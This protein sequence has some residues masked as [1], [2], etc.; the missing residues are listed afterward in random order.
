M[1]P[2]QIKMLFNVVMTFVLSVILSVVLLDVCVTAAGTLDTGELFDLMGRPLPEEHVIVQTPDPDWGKEDPDEARFEVTKTALTSSARPGDTVTYEIRIENTGN[3]DLHSV[4]STE[5]FLG[6]GIK[7]VF[8]PKE[9]QLL[10]A[11]RSQALIEKISPGETVVLQAQVVVPENVSG[12]ELVNQVIVT[13]AETGERR[14]TSEAAVRVSGGT[15]TAS[16]GNTQARTSSGGGQ[17]AAGGSR[18]QAAGSNALAPVS[19]VRTSDPMKPGF[20]LGLLLLAGTAMGVTLI[21]SR[22]R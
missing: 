13:T 15:G 1:Y 14:Q 12:Q 21:S 11:D 5:K 3:V 17:T 18:T 6:A 2:G 9:G 7:A 16:N 4:V 10:N 19:P 22:K 8:L 20:Y